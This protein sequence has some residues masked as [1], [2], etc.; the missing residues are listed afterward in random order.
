VR[1]VTDLVAAAAGHDEQAWNELVRR[2][3]GL[4]A[5]T[6]R[7]Y[8]LRPEDAQDVTQLVWLHL[9][10]HLSRLRDPAALPGWLV[11][12]TRRECERQLRTAGRVVEVDPQTMWHAAGTPPVDEPLLAYERRQALRD[13]L[14]ELDPRQRRLMVLLTADPQPSYAEIGRVLGIPVGSVG[15]T[16]ARALAKLR[17]TAPVRSYIDGGP[18]RA[19]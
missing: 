5:S 10:E 18:A 1:E 14:A 6:L 17:A 12:T 3:A 2:Y 7:R 11:T 19:A 15:P 9:V 13:G 8:R 16:R 4:I